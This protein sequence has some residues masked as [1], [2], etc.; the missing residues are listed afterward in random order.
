MSNQAIS[1]SQAEV[2]TQRWLER[3]VIG[4]NL[5]PFAKAVHIRGQIHYAVYLPNEEGGLIDALIAEAHALAACEPTERDT[6]LLIAPNTLA[7]FLD[8]ND[9]TARAER[10]LAQAGFEGQFQLASFH[11]HFQF[12]G[13][14]AVDI[15]NATNR[16]PY[17]TLHLLRED[18]VSRAVDAFPDAEAI[19]GRNIDTLEALGAEG[20]AALGVGPGGAA[21]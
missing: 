15:T 17:P 6:T 1:S 14:D 16:A 3:A 2:D 9:F 21:R 19:F 18:S 12:A 20:W 10:R 4:L 13:T 7:D 11:P 8:F 5:C